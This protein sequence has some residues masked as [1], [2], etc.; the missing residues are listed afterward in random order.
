MYKSIIALTVALAFGA[1]ASAAPTEQG[2]WCNSPKNEQFWGQASAECCR[3]NGGHM[4]SD[5]RCYGLLG[6]DT[7]CRNFY[8]CCIGT[9]SSNNHVTD[10]CY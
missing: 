10:K 8:A 6:N 1:V 2:S 9:W 5:R 7:S 4:G 3:Q